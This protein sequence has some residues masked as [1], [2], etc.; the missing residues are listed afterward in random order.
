MAD[1]GKARYLISPEAAE[2]KAELLQELAGGKKAF[3]L[4]PGAQRG[5]A[6]VRIRKLAR[7]NRSR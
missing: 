2:E 7:V 5:G 6:S 3:A 1:K 4:E